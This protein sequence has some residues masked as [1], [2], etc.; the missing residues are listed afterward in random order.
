MTTITYQNH[1]VQIVNGPYPYQGREYVTV[2][3]LD[4]SAPWIEGKISPAPTAYTVVALD[5][6]DRWPELEYTQ[7]EY[8]RDAR[9]M[10]LFDRLD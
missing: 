8:S 6:L 10:R 4:G 2:A 1:P 7:E 3:T 9:L 5:E